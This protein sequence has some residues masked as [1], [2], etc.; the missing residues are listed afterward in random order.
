[1]LKT[2]NIFVAAVALAWFAY[3]AGLQSQQCQD[4]PLIQEDLK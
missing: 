4:H 2:I 3:Q 1:M